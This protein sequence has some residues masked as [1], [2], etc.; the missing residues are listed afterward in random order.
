MSPAQPEGYLAAP[1]AEGGHPVLVLH[2]WWGLNAA[3]KAFCDRLAGA[4]FVAFA[5]DLYHGRVA[6]TIPAAEALAGALR[7]QYP[8]AKAEVAEAARFVSQRAGGSGR[9][10]AVIGFSLG[11]FYALDLAAADSDRLRSVVLFYGTGGGDF[12]RSKAAFLGHFAGH[13]PYE[14]PA[15]VDALELALKQ[16]GC[17]VTFHRYPGTGHWFF[18]P[19]RSDAYHPAAAGLAWERTLAFL[20]RPAE[21]ENR[22]TEDEEA[23]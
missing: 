14:P 21:L 12:S 2:A 22:D 6:D 10:L 4:G 18:E 16:A 17:P 13:D 9:G 5:P 8:R 19:D 15:E 3:L 20:N 7:P 1:P 11:A 23:G